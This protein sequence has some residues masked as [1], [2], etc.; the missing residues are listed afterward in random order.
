MAKWVLRHAQIVLP[1]RTLPLGYVM[2]N[3]DRLEAIGEGEPPEALSD[4]ASVDGE[5]GILAPGFIDLHV[6]GGGG[7][8]FMDGTL[9]AIVTAARAHLSHGTTT[10]AP[11][12]LACS[13]EELFRFFAHYERALRVENMP[14]LAGIHLE[15]PYFSKNQA[16]AQPP[17]YLRT[18]V[19]EHYQ[20]ILERGRGHII[21]WSLAPE[22][23]GALAL[24][25][26]LKER[27][28]LASIGHSDADYDAVCRAMEHGFTH[29]THFYSGMSSLTRREGFRVLGVV[30]CG[31]LFDQLH[32]EIIADGMHLPPELLRLIVKQR[33]H[34]QISLVTDAMRGAGMPEGPSVLG[35]QEH[36]LPVVVQG[37]VARMLDLSGFAGSVAT[38]DRLVRTM[39][40]LARLALHEAVAMMTLHPAR[41]LGREAE[42]GSLQPGKKADLVL[43]DQQLYAR[44]VWVGGKEIQ[45]TKEA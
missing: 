3:G 11:T 20:A 38:T 15:G 36:G 37:G 14:R 16:G 42:L 13:D 23:D 4:L 21:R 2:V 33:P 1:D 44:R 5:G 6:H 43:L 12:T 28:I 31:Y 41:L 26:V 35:S 45:S 8:D 9:E 7:C 25:D 19:P 29:I 24:G 17:E 27:G 30:E 22:L 40:R 32:T 10:I 34:E 18:P 39:V